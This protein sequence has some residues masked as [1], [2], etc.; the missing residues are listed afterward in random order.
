MAGE[1]YYNTKTGEVEEG[2]RS[3]WMDLMGPYD[4]E[5][6]ARNALKTAAERNEQA[7]AEEEAWNEWD[8]DGEDD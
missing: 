5:E 1:Y 8:E 4:T 3:G 6:E 2:K 7:D